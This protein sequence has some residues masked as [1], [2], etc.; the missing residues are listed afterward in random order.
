M[1]GDE[2]PRRPAGEGLVDI[3]G[4]LWV[5]QR[6]PHAVADMRGAFKVPTLRNVAETAPY[7]HDGRHRTLQDVIEHYRQPPDPAMT[8]HELARTK[9][10]DVEARQLI[11]FLGTLTGE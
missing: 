10:S 3:E 9:L 7:L 4:G 1:L 11:A 2:A 5:L 6:D 8:R